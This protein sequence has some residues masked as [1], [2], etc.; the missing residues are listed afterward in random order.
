MSLELLIDILI[1]TVP[2]MPSRP[3]SSARLSRVF[4]IV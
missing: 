4:K 3:G 1:A 2:L